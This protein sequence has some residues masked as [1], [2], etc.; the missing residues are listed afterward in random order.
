M[1]LRWRYWLLP[2]LMIG[3]FISIFEV[4][5]EGIS[6]GWGDQWDTYLPTEYTRDQFTSTTTSPSLAL[7]TVVLNT[8]L[9]RTKLHFESASTIVSSH[10]RWLWQHQI[11]LRCCQ[12]RI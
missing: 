12:W 5:T 10:D 4:N 3:M 9:H 1:K 6:N 2:V 8:T 11:F 7:G